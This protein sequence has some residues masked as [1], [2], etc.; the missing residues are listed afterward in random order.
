[1]NP[2]GLR[3]FRVAIVLLSAAIG[4]AAVF[5]GFLTTPQADAQ[6]VQT[7]GD[8]LPSFEVASIKLCRDREN[9]HLSILP[10][11][12]TVRNQPVQFLLKIAYGRDFGQF[13]FRMLRDNEIAGGPDWVHGSI[14][15]YDGY[16]V[17][18]KVEDSVAAKF[19]KLR[20]GSFFN[21]PCE[22][23][24]QML[25]MLQSL[26]AERFKL[27]VRRDIKQLPVYDLAI[28]KGGPK[29]LH[30]KFETSD[31]PAHRAD[32]TLPAP[33]PPPC[34]TDL[35][36]WHYYVS[37]SLV[38]DLL[39]GGSQIGRPVLDRTGLKGGYYL[40]L[41]FALQPSLSATAPADN[42]PPAGPVGPSIFAA[43]EQQL[44]LKLKPT[45]GPVESIVIEHI[46]RPTEN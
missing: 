1:M 40:D 10:N 36:C 9:S 18:A 42:A 46:E 4:A 15:G 32:P 25:L 20:C 37:M 24:G 12:L 45:K 17:D 33:A 43:L 44:G 26:L 11:R 23:R 19:A 30:T 6:S 41:Q 13:G 39:S 8:T 22:Y 27:K 3:Q 34:P 31:D 28:A 14:S 35:M 16:D 2:T 7:A 21:G 29:F 38:A 5:F